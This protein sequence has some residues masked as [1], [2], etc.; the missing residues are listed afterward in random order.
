[1]V[2][3]GKCTGGPKTVFLMICSFLNCYDNNFHSRYQYVV[4]AASCI[5]DYN[6]QFRKFISLQCT[7]SFSTLRIANLLLLGDYYK[8]AE[9]PVA[10]DIGN[11]HHQPVIL[12]C[13]PL[14][15]LSLNI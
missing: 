13:H 11:S 8:L 9:F 2:Y 15:Q 4:L 12:V 3:P 10:E 7:C 14:V 1:M 5:P 6:V